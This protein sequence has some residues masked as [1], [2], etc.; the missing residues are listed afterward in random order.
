MWGGG[1]PA[2]SGS[3]IIVMFTWSVMPGSKVGNTRHFI[4]YKVH[5][6][7]RTLPN[8]L[9][10]WF[11]PGTPVSSTRKLISSSFH[12]L[13]MTLAVAEALNPNKPNQNF[14]TSLLGTGARRRVPASFIWDRHTRVTTCHRVSPR[15]NTYQHIMKC[16]L[17][18]RNFII[19][20]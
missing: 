20:I 7:C 16:Y 1:R 12:R 17:L 8:F 9:G 14:Q 3:S 5:L 18:L 11:P 2:T 19:T 10:R 4:G 15:V 6:W 13:H